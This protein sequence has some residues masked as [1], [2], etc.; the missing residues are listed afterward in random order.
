[1]LL[2]KSDMFGVLCQYRC[3]S[4]DSELD[5]EYYWNDMVQEL[6]LLGHILNWM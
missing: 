5:L 1:M 6:S 3:E 2:S 4:E